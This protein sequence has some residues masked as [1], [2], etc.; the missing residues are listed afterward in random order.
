MEDLKVQYNAAL[1]FIESV[2]IQQMMY[3]EYQFPYFYRTH[4]SQMY[5]HSQ[6]YRSYVEIQ[7]S[8]IFRGLKG[9]ILKT[10]PNSQT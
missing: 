1:K 8:K 4:E 3:E 7:D 5:K 6:Q 10:V 2:K 9:A